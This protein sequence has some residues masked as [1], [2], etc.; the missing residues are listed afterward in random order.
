MTATKADKAQEKAKEETLKENEKIVAAQEDQAEQ[1]EDGTLATDTVVMKPVEPVLE[2]RKDRV[3]YKYIEEPHIGVKL[4]VVQRHFK[5]VTE[6][7]T[8]NH[9]QAWELY[10]KWVA[11]GG[12][13]LQPGDAWKD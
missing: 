8:P 2:T 6:T 7:I 13:V 4:S 1:A 9:T 3:Q 11:E 12:E 5:G 10:G